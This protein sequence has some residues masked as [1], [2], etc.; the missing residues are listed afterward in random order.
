M[1]DSYS[2][3]LIQDGRLNGDVF[4]GGFAGFGRRHLPGAAGRTLAEGAWVGDDDGGGG[5]RGVLGDVGP[6][7][8]QVHQRE[9]V[10]P[11]VNAASPQHFRGNFNGG[12]GAGDGFARGAEDRDGLELT[13]PDEVLERRLKPVLGNNAAKAPLGA[14][15]NAEGRGDVAT[16]IDEHLGGGTFKAQV[17][18]ALPAPDGEDGREQDRIDPETSMGGRPAHEGG[19]GIAGCAGYSKLQ[20]SQGNH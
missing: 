10:F 1:T 3:R 4:A 5:A 14:D 16:A 12:P 2:S 20:L 17:F 13:G 8:H 6:E 7:I 9:R 15:D 19:S 18:R 11:P